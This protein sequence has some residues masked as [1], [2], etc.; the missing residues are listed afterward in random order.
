MSA[1]K[2]VR[3]PDILSG[4]W[5]LE[6]TM[7]PIADVRREARLGR[8][9]LKERYAAINLTDEEIDAIMAFIFP[10]IREPS[11]TFERDERIVHCVC[12][13]STSGPGPTIE[14]PC[15]R[16]WHVTAELERL[17]DPGPYSLPPDG[18]R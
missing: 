15:G 14:C 13:E 8:D 3:G 1:R 12:G 17:S 9:G 7:T 16:T 6:D 4:R 10:A 11:L 18:E 2:I 5:R